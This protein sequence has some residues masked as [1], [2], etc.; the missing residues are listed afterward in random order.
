LFAV[1]QSLKGN[2][3]VSFVNKTPFAKPCNTFEIK[4]NALL[5]CLSGGAT[6]NYETTTNKN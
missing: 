3:N 6:I 5:P 4:I 1:I 2:I